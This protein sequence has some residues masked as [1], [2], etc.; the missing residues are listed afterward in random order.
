MSSSAVVDAPAA[1]EPLPKMLVG[2]FHKT[3]TMLLLAI[4]R[5]LSRELGYQF[6]MPDGN[7]PPKGWNVILHVHSRFKKSLM[8]EGHPTVIV[9]RDPRDVIVSGAYYHTKL[10]TPGDKW[11]HVPDER[12]GGLTYQQKMMS[13]PNDEERFIFEMTNR[14]ANTLKNMRRFVDPSP[15]IYLARFEDLVTDPYMFEYA[16]LFSWLRLPPRYLGRALDVAYRNSIFSGQVKTPHVRSGRP[17]QWQ[18]LF[19]PRV[20]DSFRHHFGD[21]AE[22]FGYPAA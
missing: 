10:V 9:I 18:Q 7:E 13:L 12:F 4:F 6:W 22:K 20:H 15:N 17:A 21:L 14:G 3:G 19:T 8:D 2:T 16:R 5:Q 1:E 11:L